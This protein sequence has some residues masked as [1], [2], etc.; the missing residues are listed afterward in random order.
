VPA[1]F[2]FCDH[3]QTYSRES[4]FGLWLSS[5]Y[6]FFAQMVLVFTVEG[7]TSFHR[8]PIFVL[9]LYLYAHAIMLG[10]SHYES[11][12]GILCVL[13]VLALFIVFNPRPFDHLVLWVELTAASSIVALLLIKNMGGLKAGACSL[14]GTA[15]LYAEVRIRGIVPERDLSTAM[16]TAWLNI[17]G[18]KTIG[19]L[20]PSV[21]TLLGTRFYWV[22]LMTAGAVGLHARRHEIASIRVR[23]WGIAK[24]RVKLHTYPVRPKRNVGRGI[25]SAVSSVLSWVLHYV[26]QGIFWIGSHAWFVAGNA[27]CM[28]L[29]SVL[30]AARE[31]LRSFLY[32]LQLLGQIALGFLQTFW[33]SSLMMLTGVAVAFLVFLLPTLISALALHEFALTASSISDAIHQQ[34][35]SPYAVALHVFGCLLVFTLGIGIALWSIRPDGSSTI[36]WQQARYHGLHLSLAAWDQFRMIGASLMNYSRCIGS[37]LLAAYVGTLLGFDLLHPVFGGPYRFGY[38]GGTIVALLIVN[39]L[40]TR[41]RGREA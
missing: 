26:A 25:F 10:A 29:F 2:P 8:W 15:W 33:L 34:N 24:W 3:C 40:V 41:F 1:H 38:L 6:A 5:G 12:R 18:V 16:H 31:I 28:L 13:S 4:L 21:V 17:T 37:K 27:F 9:L 11:Q 7:F 39:F 36:W 14:L 20:V 35:A 30:W 32:L 22:F 23:T 19:G